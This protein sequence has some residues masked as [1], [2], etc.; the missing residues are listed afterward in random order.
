MNATLP[1]P[2][3]D[4]AHLEAVEKLAQGLDPLALSWASG[5]LAGLS[6]ARSGVAAALHGSLASGAA[7]EAHTDAALR[8]T[9]LYASQTG[10]GRRV[11]E[12]LARS[13]EASGLA[14]RLVSAA[15]FTPREL[16]N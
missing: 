1:A 2:I 13:A 15:D 11:A 14:V 8:A 7:V 12:R 4:A 5:Y 3:L 9:I 16:A 6:R 10:N